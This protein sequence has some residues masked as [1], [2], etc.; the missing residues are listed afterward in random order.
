M[1]GRRLG[2]EERPVEV[3][4]H[5]LAPVVDRQAG[6]RLDRLPGGVVDDDVG[7]DVVEQRRDVRGPREVR[8]DDVT[9]AEPFDE[10][11][12]RGAVGVRVRDDPGTG[13]GEPR[14]DAAAQVAARAGDERYPA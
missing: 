11:L 1:R 10:R 5:D 9:V 12:G 14:R 13:V 3:G 7:R 2:D 4:A 6:Q 8:F